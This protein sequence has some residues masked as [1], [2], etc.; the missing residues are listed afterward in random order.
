VVARVPRLDRWAPLAGVVF[1]VLSFV[2]ALLLSAG[3]FD[4]SATAPS[5]LDDYRDSGTRLRM[6]IGHSLTAVGAIFFIVFLGQLRSAL[7]VSDREANPWAA[8]A[9]IAGG[10]F[11]ALE[12]SAATALNVVADAHDYFDAYRLDAN[13]VIAFASLSHGLDIA[14][15]AAACALLIVSGFGILRA[16]RLPRWSAWFSLAAAV[17]TLL[18]GLFGGPVL[19]WIW[20]VLL[21]V[22]LVR[23]PLG[24]RDSS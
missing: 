11:I 14:T 13:D 24:A 3:T 16:G 6:D 15:A 1:A 8:A 20:A 5:I 9:S 12:L 21:S 4:A 2:G 17:P 19:L 22:L 10:V 7:A 23:S 18:L